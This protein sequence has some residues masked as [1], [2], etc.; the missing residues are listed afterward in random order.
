MKK[1]T[2]VLRQITFG[3]ELDTEAL[4]GR[5]IVE[6]YSNCRVLIELHNG[7]VEYGQEKISVRVRYGQVCICGKCLEVMKM[8]SHQLVISGDIQS[9]HLV[10]R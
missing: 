1:A 9:V 2:G 8:T 4:P 7:I 10:R 6:I 5:P 3:T